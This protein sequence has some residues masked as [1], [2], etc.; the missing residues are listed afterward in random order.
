MRVGL[1]VAAWGVVLLAGCSGGALNSL[2]QAATG[3]AAGARLAGVVHGGQ[4]PIV[5]AHVYLFAANTT[6][7]GGAGIAASTSNASLS[8][9]T[10]GSGTTQDV[11]GG[12]TNGDYYVTTDGSG[13]FSISGDYTCTAGQQVY[14]YAL[15]G[16]PGLGRTR[17]SG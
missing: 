8:L 4:Q 13:S 3:S 16:N 17:L 11:S 10:S 2:D 5:G 9:L 1:A 6:G 15:G 12:A 7:Y 14:L